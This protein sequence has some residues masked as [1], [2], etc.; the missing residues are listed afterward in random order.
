MIILNI[1]NILIIILMI[2]LIIIMGF[3]ILPIEYSA[4]GRAEENLYGE[5]NIRCLGGLIGFYGSKDDVEDKVKFKL[6]LCG[7]KFNIKPNIPSK[8]TDVLKTKI[9][10]K[11]QNKSKSKY[12]KR[13]FSKDAIKICINYFK[14][15]LRITKPNNVEIIGV[16]GFEDPSVTGIICGLISIINEFVPKNNINL[17][18]VFDDTALDIN[19]KVHGKVFLSNVAFK[20]LRF[21]MKKDIR[22]LIFP[23]KIKNV[24]HL[25]SL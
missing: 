12:E 8:N 16:Y 22:K 11:V 2:I 25:K 14:D 3:L 10:K 17:Q 19:L 4:G 5:V 7:I 9:K 15:I 13:S 24:K 21:I 23:K 18:P 20:S 1:L 6:S